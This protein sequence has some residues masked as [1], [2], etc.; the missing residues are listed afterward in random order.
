V[1]GAGSSM[2]V[3]RM[4]V[5]VDAGA[6]IAE[7]S[8]RFREGI[9]TR[10]ATTV[11]R[12]LMQAVVGPR[13]A[14][15]VQAML[16]NSPTRPRGRAKDLVVSLMVHGILLAALLVIPLYFTEAIDLNQL[17][18]TLLVAPPAPAL[19]PPPI[20]AAVTRPLAPP[21]KMLPVAGKLVAPRVIPNQIARSVKDLGATDLAA[22]ITPGVPGGVPGGEAGDVLGGI[23]AGSPPSSLPPPPTGPPPK[24]LLRVGGE[25]RE[26]RLISRVEPVY[27][28]ILR[29]AKVSGIVVIDAVI[30][31]QGNV[32]QMHPVSGD[33]LL[34]P[35]AMD[36]LRRWKYAPTILGGQAYPVELTVTIEFRLS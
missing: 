8:G 7:S 18:H 22:A 20:S 10:G 28:L 4:L 29:R 6:A 14:L 26:P 2:L 24:A 34:I 31:I 1:K 15:F 25:V 27:P 33:Q 30:D 13:P 12:G 11:S 3:P 19:P 9:R 32:V 21:K 23:I 16:E 36:A 35:P 17:D 5:P